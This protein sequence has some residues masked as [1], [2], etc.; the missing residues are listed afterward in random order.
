MSG[1]LP[2]PDSIKTFEHIETPQPINYQTETVAHFTTTENVL[3]LIEGAPQPPLTAAHDLSPTEILPTLTSLHSVQNSL[4]KA[5]DTADLRQVMRAALQTTTDAEML[6]VLQVGHHEMP[7]AI[8]TLQRALEHIAERDGDG[9][10]APPEKGVVLAKVVK[11]VNHNEVEGP[12]GPLKRSRTIISIDSTST[13]SSGHNS[14]R[15]RDT[16][17]REFVECGIDCLR[18]MSRGIETSLPSWT[19][20]K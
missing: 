4:D 17:D 9:V 6:E 7:D 15:R 14:E 20:T 13:T 12:G 8:K 19:I 10:E 16:L 11:K 5:M 2:S 18:R 1:R 3:G